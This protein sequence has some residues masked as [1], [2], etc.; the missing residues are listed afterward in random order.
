MKPVQIKAEYN[1]LLEMAAAFGAPWFGAASF[2]S[3]IC[4]SKEDY[5]F[6]PFGVAV[7]IYS[8]FR[9]NEENG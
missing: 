1:Q 5:Q 9:L 7:V 2:I 6:T 4:R 8:V 3:K